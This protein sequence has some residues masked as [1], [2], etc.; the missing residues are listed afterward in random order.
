MKPT[1]LLLVIVSLALYNVGTIWAHEVDIFRSW[2]LVDPQNFH[3]I[4]RAHWRKL[5]YW[6]FTPVALAIAGNIAL[7]WY[8]P[9]NSPLWAIWAAL[10]CQMLSILL[11][12]VFWGPWQAKLSQDPLGPKSVYLAKILA[13][14]W[15]RTFLINANAFILLFWTIRILSP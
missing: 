4:Q 5:P 2:R 9:A 14:H 1:V 13:T 6:I 3:E 10:L 15:V 11:T 7:I 8:H 12:A